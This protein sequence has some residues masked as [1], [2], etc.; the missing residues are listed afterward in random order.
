MDQH[1]FS[2]R[3][4]KQLD[5]VAYLGTLGFL[6]QKI[7][8]DDYWYR[9]P[10][11][12]EKE[13]S[14]KINKH[15][16]I[17]YDHGLGKGGTLID[18]GVMYHQY[19]IPELLQKLRTFSFHQPDT[20]Q[21][22][23]I[24]RLERPD[25]IITAN[26]DAGDPGKINILSVHEIS[27]YPLIRYLE[28]R[29]IPSEIADRY[30][31]EIRYENHGKIYYALGFKNDAGGYELR[32]EKFKGSSAPKSATLIDNRQHQVAVFEGFF[33]FLSFQTINRNE[34]EPLTNFLV[35]NSLAFLEKSRPLMEQYETIHL[36]LD[37]DLAG[38]K[39]TQKA[40][41][42]DRRYIDRSDFYAHH[43][44]LNQWLQENSFHHRHERRLGRS[45]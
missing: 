7:K 41:Q 6:P 20:D 31:K 14:F 33:S 26:K 28:S 43:K 29:K 36:F 21:P 34:E 23:G 24:R 5:L 38:Q 27:S 45:R 12:E 1:T 19:S 8:G 39:F 37:R 4:A 16:N 42:W 25:A 40:L 2:C 10:F 17:W 9:S 3:V 30:C 15:F 18:F 11:R 22:I 44:D 32:S 35:L 13:P